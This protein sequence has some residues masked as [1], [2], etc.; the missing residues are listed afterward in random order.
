MG[1]EGVGPSPLTRVLVASGSGKPDPVLGV[2]DTDPGVGQNA[3]RLGCPRM[4]PGYDVVRLVV[5]VGLEIPTFFQS[6]AQRFGMAPRRRLSINILGVDHVHTE[7]IVL[8]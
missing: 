4:V 2:I 6:G 7:Q 5:V 1:A 3:P 8:V